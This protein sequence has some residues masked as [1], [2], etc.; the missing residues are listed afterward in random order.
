MTTNGV[1]TGLKKFKCMDQILTTA[2]TECMA[3][4]ATLSTRKE[5]L[6]LPVFTEAGSAYLAILA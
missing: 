3:P 4:H 5:I 2:L 6:A 1:R